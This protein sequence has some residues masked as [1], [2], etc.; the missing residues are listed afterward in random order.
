MT[1]DTRRFDLVI[2][3]C[4]GVLVDSE[5]LTNGVFAQ[6]LNELGV[7]VTLDD[8]FEAFV[9]HSMAHCLDLVAA[10]LGE[11]PPA[12]FEDD[13]RRRTRAVLETDLRATPGVEEALDALHAIRLPCCVA[14]SGDHDKMR[15]TLGLTGLWPR[16]AG[17]V[18]SVTEVPRSKPFP[19]V[20]LLAAA[21]CG[22]EPSACAVVEDTPVGVAAGVAA[23]MTV[24]GYAAL[25]PARRLI[26]AGAH[27]TFGHMRDLPRLLGA[28][29]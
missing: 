27:V 28:M 15:T 19:D 8:M 1:S 25:T 3:D 5:R 14:S 17:R 10:R 2:F 23:G 13:Y 9:G 26:E 4:D 29:P 12:A 24:L 18:F 22:A 16:V 11:P 7:A 20:F 6:M 21:R